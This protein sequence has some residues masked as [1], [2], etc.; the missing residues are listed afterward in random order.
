MLST[1]LMLLDSEEDQQRFEE[2]YHQYKYLMVHIA[3]DYFPEKHQAED[4]VQ[5]AFLRIIKN[6]S[7]IKEINC[8][9]TRRFIVIVIRSTCI[10]L[11]R[12]GKVEKET[13]FLEDVLEADIPRE[14]EP[15]TA[16]ERAEYYNR[17]LEALRSFSEEYRNVLALRWVQKLSRAEISGIT[18]L[19][20]EY[21]K[22]ILVRSRKKLEEMM[23][24]KE[25]I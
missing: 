18:G 4:A 6:F 17:L 8:P 14:S 2:L 20:E 24:E 1:F 5:E 15:V 16:L 21:I 25:V 13:L 11:L 23:T 9:Q 12:M 10:D 19:S 22:K 7:K 3:K